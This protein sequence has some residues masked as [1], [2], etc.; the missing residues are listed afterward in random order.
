ME[1]L[2]ILNQ[3]EQR[4]SDIISSKGY[5]MVN[6]VVEPSKKGFGDITC[7]IGFLLA[8]K[9]NKKPQE[10]SEEFVNEFKSNLVDGI[11]KVES[12]PSGYLNF[13]INI[14]SLAESVLLN[15]QKDSYGDINIGNNTTIVVEH[16]SVNPNKALHIGHLRNVV[17]GDSISRILEK[18]NYNVKVLNYV[19]DSGLQVA[20]I[21]VGFKFAGYS[22]TPPS[23]EKFAHYCGDTVY[24]KT[25]QKYEEDKGI[26]D[27][28]NYVTS[29]YRGHYT[30][31]QNNTQ[32]L[33]LIQSVGDA[34]SFCRSNA[35]K[36]LARYDKKGSA[37]QD[38]LKAMHYCLLLYYFS[39][40]TKE[41]DYTNTRYETF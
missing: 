30:S 4:I 6:F 22:E 10:I 41:P 20:D 2:E 27:L 21:I 3:V 1:F 13:F 16:T 5:E 39:G 28:K 17:I 15:S 36:Y 14:K 23:G 12:H 38:I 24:V 34:E 19:D 7:N 40:N 8:K 35:L 11:Q 32:T 9:L 18:A 37:K 33:D 25:T 26:A 31:E 29:T